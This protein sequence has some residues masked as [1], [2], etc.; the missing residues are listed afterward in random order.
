MDPLEIIGFLTTILC[1]WLSAKERAWG[2]P[3][4]AVASGF[5]CVVYYQARLYLDSSLQVFFLALSLYGWYE[6]L[7][8]GQNKD[9]LPISRLP[10]VAIPYL[11][12]IGLLATATMGY[13]VVHLRPD[14]SIPYL[15]AATTA[16]S[17]IAQWMLARKYLEN[18]LVWIA[19]DPVYTG[20]YVY[21]GLYLTAFLYLLITLMAVQGYLHWKRA[22]TTA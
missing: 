12:T 7:Y 1:V 15:D 17:L 2:F 13:A 6:W 3:V 20:I 16:T 14:A 8:G 22:L 18:W 21:K 10:R 19:V 9:V 5:Y 11:V 4:A